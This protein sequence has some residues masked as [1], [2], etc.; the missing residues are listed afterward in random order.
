MKILILP[1]KKY[2]TSEEKRQYAEEV[3]S[4]KRHYNSLGIE[5]VE[6]VE[7]DPISEDELVKT[8]WRRGHLLMATAECDGTV[9]A[10]HNCVEVTE[11]K[12]IIFPIYTGKNN[13]VIR[14]EIRNPF[15]Y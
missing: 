5:C 2:A 15:S 8:L 6:F 1:L 9:L 13:L 4:A 7:P 3:A 11:A 12:T 14:K 10:L